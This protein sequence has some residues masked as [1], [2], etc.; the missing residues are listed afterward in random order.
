MDA[1]EAIVAAEV[2]KTMI[3]EGYRDILK[4]SA[5]KTGDLLALFPRAMWVMLGDFHLWLLQKEENLRKIG[6]AITEKTKDIPDDQLVPP[7]PYVAI[8]AIQSM[9]YCMDSDELRDMYA[10]LLASSMCKI[11]K[12]GVMPAFVD[13]IKQLCPDEAKILKFV[14]NSGHSR[15]IPAV[16][17]K[18]SK[19]GEFSFISLLINH[20]LVGKEAGCEFPS[21]TTAYLDNLTRLGLITSPPGAYLIAEGFYSSLEECEEVKKCMKIPQAF[22]DGGYN[23]AKIEK[24]CYRMT[25]FGKCFCRSCVEKP[26]EVLASVTVESVK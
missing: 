10:N 8:P 9:S 25:S 5:K 26:L 3:K 12:S 11:K 21:N 14:Y 20:S 4:P 19:E 2:A 15:Y 22:R 16:T 23:K 6:E 17:V 13:I 1:N 7:E 24:S 18:L